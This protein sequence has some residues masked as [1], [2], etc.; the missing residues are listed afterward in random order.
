MDTL[1]PDRS[2]AAHVAGAAVTIAQYAAAALKTPKRRVHVAEE[3]RPWLQ[4]LDRDGYCVVPGFAS[5]ERCR[6]SMAEIDRLFATYPT[7]VQRRSDRRMFGV[8]AG[9]AVLAEFA[10]DPRLLAM[11]EQVLREPA[12]NAFTLGSRID[13]TPNNKGSGEGW[14]RDSFVVQFKALLYLSDV[15]LGTG[16]FQLIAD[17]EKLSWLV[18]D[19]L[20]ARLGL[21]QNRVQEAQIERL[22]QRRPQRQKTFVA[23]AGTL[24]L[25]NTSAIHR[26]Q[27]LEHGTRYALTNYFVQRRRAGAAMDAHFAPV[28]RRSEAVFG[29]SADSGRV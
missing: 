20:R 22:L 1:G 16:P 25:V 5:P 10:H 9:S 24:L 6:R 14:H 23:P 28:L 21:A 7:Y 3:I 15:Q 26:G 2:R 12:V 4:A 19:M 18:R 27:P 13:F 29:T 17:S 8:E 11:A